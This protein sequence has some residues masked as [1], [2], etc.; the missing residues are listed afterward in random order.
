LPFPAESAAWPTAEAGAIRLE[1][2]GAYAVAGV[3]EM[4]EPI[5]AAFE[6]A[7]LAPDEA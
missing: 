1:T 2:D 3:H 5:A 7:G 6:R 4:I